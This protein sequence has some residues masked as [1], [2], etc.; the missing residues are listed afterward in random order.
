MARA[1]TFDTYV[2]EITGTQFWRRTRSYVRREEG[3]G[4]WACWM[5]NNDKD[6]FVFADV[7]FDEAGNQLR[8]RRAYRFGFGFQQDQYAESYNFV[9]ENELEVL[10]KMYAGRGYVVVAA[11]EPSPP[12]EDEVARWRPFSQDVLRAPSIG[13]GNHQGYEKACGLFAHLC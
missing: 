12:T 11:S 9:D 13:D 1:C 5:S 10:R 2:H 7:A 3:A 8:I 4:L 6:L